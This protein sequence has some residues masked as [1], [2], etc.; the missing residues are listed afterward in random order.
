MSRSVFVTGAYGLLGTWLVKGLLDRGDRVVVVRRDRAPNSA[1]VI[2]GLQDRCDVVQGDILDAAL[3]DRVIGEY[4]VDTVFHLA[5]QTIV[6]TANRSPAATFDTNIR[7]T[8]TVLEACRLHGVARTI[9]ASSDK[10]YGSQPVLP[11]SEDMPL[12]ARHPYDASKAAADMLARSYWTT[13]ELPVAVTRLANLYGGGD[14]N[15]SRL[16]PGAIDAALRGEAP[17]IRSDGS[18]ERDYLHVEDAVA[19]YLAIADLLDEEDPARSARGEAFNAGAGVPWRVDAVVGLVCD[20]AGTGVRPDVRGAGVP[21]GEIDR[22]F[23]DS[24]K[25]RRRTG[26]EPKIGLA[27]GIARTVEW[28]RAHPS[29]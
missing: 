11:Y 16:I 1:L 5:A 18:P 26:W 15:P 29:R 9:V 17:V 22:Q 6:G 19:A 4:D 20:A 13:Y 28:H 10:A 8:W 3:M 14:L 23:L 2:E 12:L 21:H 25:L 27:E 24:T 7:G